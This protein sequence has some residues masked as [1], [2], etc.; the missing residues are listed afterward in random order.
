MFSTQTS[1]VISILQ[2]SPLLPAL[3]LHL[4]TLLFP[5]L[6]RAERGAPLLAVACLRQSMERIAVHLVELAVAVPI[7]ILKL[8]DRGETPERALLSP[9]RFAG[10]APHLSGCVKPW[11]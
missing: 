1:Q 3:L 8:A 4:L 6:Q 5:S 2:L 7:N 9:C 11:Y 10:W